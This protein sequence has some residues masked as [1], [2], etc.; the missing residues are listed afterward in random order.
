MNPWISRSI[1]AWAPRVPALVM[2]LL[3]VTLAA[4]C[5]AAGKEPY[6][7]NRTQPVTPSGAFVTSD[8]VAVAAGQIDQLILDA[9]SARGLQPLDVCDDLTFLRRTAL[10]LIG[11]IP[12]LAEHDRYL[13]EPAQKRRSWWIDRLMS[14][15]AFVDR[16]AVF[17]GDMLRVRQNEEGGRALH[18]FVRDALAKNEPY[19]AMV[20]RMVMAMG[21][22]QSEPAAGLL[23]M[24]RGEPLQMAAMVS[25]QFMGV[26][27]GCAQ[28]HDH[29]FDVW[30]QKDYY[31]LAAYFTNTGYV[32]RDKPRALR[33]VVS[34][35]PQVLWPPY[36]KTGEKKAPVNPVWPLPTLPSHDVRVQE[37]AKQQ[38]AARAL[39]DADSAIDGLLDA[40]AKPRNALSAVMDTDMA[41]KVADQNRDLQRA[42]LADVIVAPSNRYFAWNLVNRTWAELMGRGLVEP[43]DDFRSDNPPS[44]PKLLDALADDFVTHGHDF[45]RL[46]R[47]MV[48][49]QAY[50]RQRAIDMEQARRLELEKASL[51]S[52]L[53][54]MNA[55]MLY[56]SLITA[57]H[58][59]QPKHAP[60]ANMQPVTVTVQVPRNK[61]NAAGGSDKSAKDK[62][63]EGVVVASSF[64]AEGD[65][66]F[67]DVL[68]A[69][70]K[71]ERELAGETMMMSSMMMSTLSPAEMAK[72]AASE[73]EY[74]TKTITQM[75]DI[76]PQF[77]FASRLRA[78]APGEH[79]LRQFGQSARSIL[80]EQRLRQPTMRQA[81]IL[82]NGQLVNEAARVG[83]MEPVAKLLGAN[84]PIEPAVKRLYIEIMTRQ[85]T[86]P[87]MKVALDLI[88][89]APTVE[90]GVAD[91]RWAMLNSLEFRYIP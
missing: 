1:S 54:R 24:E 26:R 71:R 66:N 89:T 75:R 44:N 49:T 82:H 74:E 47:L 55:E 62:Q 31:G 68:M 67:D 84:K 18:E 53:R 80:G 12:T 81:L 86:D 15:P 58:L 69:A 61:A 22:P 43:V 34:R 13:N 56:D 38:A 21:T 50:Q 42:A 57:G 36:P 45:R 11:R 48:T 64:S 85:P 88:R 35:E 27:I 51:A 65:I 32:Q 40:T 87:E 52:P 20:R 76:N 30:T 5:W 60:G 70:G 73:P 90:Q 79:F 33:L 63:A 19:D 9:A 41:K 14:D 10:D 83:A 72:V 29:P 59:G 4:V 78:P 37:W 16:W 8:N 28:C 91:L 39:Q 2:A 6:R 17:F 23:I 46:V 25:Q 77:D 7:K 3:W